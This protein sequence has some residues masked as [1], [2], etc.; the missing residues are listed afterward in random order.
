M[1]KRV[2]GPT[3]TGDYMVTS[4][5]PN[6]HLVLRDGTMLEAP[7]HSKLLRILSAGASQEIKRQIC[8]IE[9]EYS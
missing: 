7:V 1:I 6:V 2:Y 9:Q 3:G 5:S 4:D 8:A